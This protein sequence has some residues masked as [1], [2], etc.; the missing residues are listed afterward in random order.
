M[1]DLRQLQT[2]VAAFLEARPRRNP[3]SDTGKMML[4]GLERYL[5]M[6][7]RDRATDLVARAYLERKIYSA[8]AAALSEEDRKRL[9]PYEGEPAYELAQ[10]DPE[11]YQKLVDVVAEKSALFY[12]VLE[13]VTQLGPEHAPSWGYFDDQTFRYPKGG[14]LVHCTDADFSSVVRDFRGVGQIDRLG[15]TTHLSRVDR[16]ER[17]AFG[18]A[19]EPDAFARYGLSRGRCKYGRTMLLLKVPDYLVA[20]HYSDEEPQA[21][22]W[23]PD[24]E[25]GLV[26]EGSRGDWGLPDGDALAEEHGLE[27]PGPFEELYDLVGWLEAHP[28]VYA[29]VV[30]ENP[31]PRRRGKQARPRAKRASK[32]A[33]SAAALVRKALK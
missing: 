32:T 11:L 8:L 13:S 15:L 18:F 6:P 29:D 27:Y 12:Q 23:G 7:H 30:I 3:A 9:L 5:K 26:F 25:A 21:L 33:K 19:F 14:W 22:F 31:A 17:E 20:W 28:E 2:D 24:I 1:K 16:Q 4:D 10:E